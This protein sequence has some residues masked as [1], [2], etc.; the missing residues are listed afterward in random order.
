MARSKN[1]LLTTLFTLLPAT[2]LLAQGGPGKGSSDNPFAG[3]REKIEAID[4]TFT[5]N[6]QRMSENEGFDLA[7]RLEQKSGATLVLDDN[8]GDQDHMVFFDPQD[9][10]AILEIDLRSRGFLYNSGMNPLRFEGETP[11]L[12]KDP[13]R[14]RELARAHLSDLGLLPAQRQLRFDRVGGLAM[15]VVHEDGSTA[16]FEKLVSVRFGRVHGDVDTEGPGSRIVV[17]LGKDGRLQGLV[18]QWEKFDRRAVTESDKIPVETLARF[19][20]LR[21]QDVTK[22]AI[23][24]EVKVAEVV[25]F[26]DGEG[27]TE[28]AVHVVAELTFEDP[29]GGVYQNPFDFYLPILRQTKALF[30]FV[31]DRNVPD[32]AR[33]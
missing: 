6:T 13:E 14:A 21:M 33:D 12:P 5:T 1:V 29:R 20:G 17:Q 11:N 25:Y 28:P 10:S 30:P 24:R 9:R 3:L 26:D 32:P 23:Q 7:H 8:R 31:E 27:R 2:T 18:W 15:A 16:Q 22:L 19:V 4:S